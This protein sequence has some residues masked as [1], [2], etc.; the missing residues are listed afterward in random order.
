LIY[1]GKYNLERGDLK[2]PWYQ[3]HLQALQKDGIMTQIAN[4]TARKEL[5]SYVLLMLW[6]AADRIHNQ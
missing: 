1:N 6:R 4:P 2:T 5:K 3:L